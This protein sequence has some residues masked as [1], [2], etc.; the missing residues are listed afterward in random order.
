MSIESNPIVQD[1]TDVAFPV[2]APQPEPFDA[3]AEAIINDAFRFLGE[4]EANA[5]NGGQ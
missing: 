1:S 3:E 4:A 2:A 5:D